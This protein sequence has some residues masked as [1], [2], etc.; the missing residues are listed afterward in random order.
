MKNFIETILN[1]ISS[2]NIFGSYTPPTIMSDEESIKSDWE[3]ICGD[4]NTV[5]KDFNNITNNLK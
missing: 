3:K 2:F 1:G 5:M 4:W